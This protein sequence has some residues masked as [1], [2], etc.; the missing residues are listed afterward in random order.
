MEVLMKGFVVAVDVA[1]NPADGLPVVVENG[2][3]MGGFSLDCWY[4]SLKSV[5]F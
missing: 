5:S 2:L 3:T 1:V 4:M